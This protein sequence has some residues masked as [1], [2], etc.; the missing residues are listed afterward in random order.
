MIY[1]CYS[2]IHTDYLIM[3]VY[4]ILNLFTL[5]FRFQKYMNIF[6]RV[7]AC[8]NFVDPDQAALIM[9]GSIVNN[10]INI[11]YLLELFG[12]MSVRTL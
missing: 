2:Y 11:Q 12:G 5:K 6:C 10:Y 4:R 3:L 1:K 9:I 8:E 7:N